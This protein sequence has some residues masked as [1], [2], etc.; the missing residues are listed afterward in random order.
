M[1]MK[2][3]LSVKPMN[4]FKILNYSNRVVKPTYKL[5]RPVKHNQ[6]KFFQ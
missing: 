6:P 2:I 3:K 1:V 4:T 5:T